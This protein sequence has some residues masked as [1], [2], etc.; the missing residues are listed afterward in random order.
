VEIFEKYGWHFR[1]HLNWASD[2]H[3]D[4]VDGIEVFGDSASH[5]IPEIVKL[6]SDE[7]TC[8]RAAWALGRIGKSAIPALTNALSSPDVLFRLSVLD[9]IYC[10]GT[11]GGPA[12][13]A[14]IAC[15]EDRNAEVQRFAANSLGW[16]HQY[17][18]FTLPALT[19]CLSNENSEIRGVALTA[20]GEFESAAKPLLPVVLDAM[21]DSDEGVRQIA[22]ETA[23]AIEPDTVPLFLAQ[24]INTNPNVR[25]AAAYGLENYGN[26]DARV[27]H[28]LTNLLN[29]ESAAVREQAALALKANNL[30]SGKKPAAP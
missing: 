12:I 30:P 22:A 13:P 20:I 10:L 27:V 28:A 17:P 21:K 18:Q 23:H 2:D 29:D 4:A 26:G 8:H 5:C 1:E 25:E 11:N 15:L 6:L 24:L 7:E 14:L 16:I 19:A 3:V 9:A